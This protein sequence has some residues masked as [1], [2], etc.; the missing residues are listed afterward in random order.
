[1][2]YRLKE[3]EQEKP[4]MYAERIQSLYDGVDLGDLKL[5]TDK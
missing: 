3:M 5:L 2:S 1:M 4:E